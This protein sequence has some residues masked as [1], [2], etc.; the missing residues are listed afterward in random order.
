MENHTRL[1]HILNLCHWVYFLDTMVNRRACIE[2][3]FPHPSR[4][5]RLVAKGGGGKV[6]GLDSRKISPH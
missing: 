2:V 1:A 3:K 6:F 5:G 4:F